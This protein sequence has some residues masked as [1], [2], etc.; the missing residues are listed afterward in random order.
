M[1]GPLLGAALMAYL[2]PESLFLATALAH[3]CLAGYTVLRIKSRAPIPVEKREAFQ[4]VPAERATTPQAVHLDPRVD[5][6]DSEDKPDKK[7]PAA[8]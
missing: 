5:P 4:T 1:I 6:D 8:A 7:E 2:R 3:A